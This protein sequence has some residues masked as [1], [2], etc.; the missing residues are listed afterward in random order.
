MSLAK[1]VSFTS[2]FPANNLHKLTSICSLNTLKLPCN[3]I[4][5][6]LTLYKMLKK[7]NMNW[8]HFQIKQLSSLLTFFKEIFSVKLLI[9]MQLTL[10]KSLTPNK[11]HYISP[12]LQPNSKKVK[13]VWV[14]ESLI[15]L[16][17]LSSLGLD[18]K[19]CLRLYTFQFNLLI[20]VKVLLTQYR[21]HQ[22]R[23]NHISKMAW[24]AV[25]N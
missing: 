25:I 4:E 11:E 21:T 19:S 6:P 17:I 1:S 12:L 5:L 2:K 15:T 7:T 24:S 9:S 22:V 8:L 18:S 16:L 14:V 23:G 13:V 20:K 10:K 3:K